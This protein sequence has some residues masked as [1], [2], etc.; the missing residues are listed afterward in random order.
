MH[1]VTPT[2]KLRNCTLTCIVTAVWPLKAATSKVAVAHGNRKLELIARIMAGVHV[3]VLLVAATFTDAYPRARV[4]DATL[5]VGRARA[6]L[7]RG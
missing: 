3:Q 7:A 4:I 1:N 2:S 5:A 6:R